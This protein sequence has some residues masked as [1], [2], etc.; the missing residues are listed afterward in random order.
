VLTPRNH[1]FRLLIDSSGITS[2]IP[3]FNKES[4]FENP[5]FDEWNTYKPKVEWEADRIPSSEDLSDSQCILQGGLIWGNT[6][7][8]LTKER[9]LYLRPAEHCR[10][11]AC[12]GIQ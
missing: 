9:E 4:R 2:R 3:R 7:S 10:I 1:A 11:L 5:V 8:P 6:D 12:G